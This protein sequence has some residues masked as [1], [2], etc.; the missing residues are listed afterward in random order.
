MTFV[1][2]PIGALFGFAM[3]FVGLAFITMV[4]GV[5]INLLGEL[6]VYLISDIRI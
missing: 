3:F 5:I 1:I 4:A 6:L 2:E